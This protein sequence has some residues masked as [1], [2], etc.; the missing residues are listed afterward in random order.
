MYVFQ[1]KDV[2]VS[3]KIRTS[4]LRNIHLKKERV[5]AESY[6][7]SLFTQIGSVLNRVD[8]ECSGSPFTP[9]SPA[10]PGFDRLLLL[11]QAQSKN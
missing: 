6:E 5:N 3:L 2:N 7:A 9:T 4:F 11:D 1:E 10:G 8:S